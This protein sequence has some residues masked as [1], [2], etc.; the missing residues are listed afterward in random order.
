MDHHERLSD[1]RQLVDVDGAE[2]L[3]CDRVLLAVGRIPNTDGLGLENAGV[4]TGKRGIVEVD[5]HFRTNVPGVFACGDAHC[6][7]SLMPAPIPWPELE[8]P[9]ATAWWWPQATERM[10]AHIRE[11]IA[12]GDTKSE[13][14]AGLVEQFGELQ[15]ADT[16]TEPLD[17][18][19]E[20]V[21]R[22]DAITQARQ[23]LRNL[24]ACLARREETGDGSLGRGR[25]P[26]E[27]GDE[28]PET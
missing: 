21:G 6:A 22:G 17:E 5:D 1:L 24:A 13:I 7:V 8:G 15:D 25:F 16:R 19:G 14:K 3:R 26:L 9:C 2:P 27:G 28:G 23:C 10:R 12:A 11:R 4:A 18:R 20:L